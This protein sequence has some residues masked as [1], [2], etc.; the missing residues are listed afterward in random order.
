MNPTDTTYAAGDV[1][2]LKSGGPAVTVLSQDGETLKV[3]FFSDEIG[4][5]REAMLPL[6]AVEAIDAGDMKDSSGEDEDEDA[7]EDE[8]DEDQP[9]SGKR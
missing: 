2:A 4:E 3:I 7:D 8:G 9:G 5:F 1:I 6:V